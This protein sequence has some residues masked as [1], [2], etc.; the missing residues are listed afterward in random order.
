[1]IKG[2]VIFCASGVTSGDFAKGVKVLPNSYEVTTFILHKS[3]KT[4]KTTTK[5]YNK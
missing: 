4:N 3:T 5:T 1:M 2:D